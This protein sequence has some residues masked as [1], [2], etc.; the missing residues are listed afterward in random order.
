MLCHMSWFEKMPEVSVVLPVFNGATTI[1]RAVRSMLQ[2]TLEEIELIVVDDGS[3]DETLR[4]LR[5][6]ED[7]RL[8]IMEAEHTGVAAA[9]NLGTA[10]ARA[11]VIARMDA[12]DFSYPHRL[13][14]QLGLLRQGYDAV[15]CQVRIVDSEERRVESMR[16]YER[17][18]NEETLS[19]DQISALRFV[20]FPLV[21]PTIL[22]KRAYFELGF[23]N[24]DFP[25]DYDL[26]LRGAGQGMRF[27]KVPQVLFDW[28]DGPNRLT[29]T[30]PRYSDDA[31]MRCRRQRLLEGPLRHIEVVDVWGAGKTGKPWLRWLREQDIKIRHLYD[32]SPRKVGN[33]IQDARVQG[34]ESL[35]EADGTPLLIAVGSENARDV[36]RPQLASRGYVPGVDAWFVA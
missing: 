21:N 20:E 9:A 5:S 34:V 11:D 3:T 32:V 8:N 12:D 6:F 36:I 23:Q 35:F 10:A 19:N 4:L 31:F 28:Y 17:W 24:D 14:E 22:A 30:D 25:E 7:P 1:E 15:G 29:R 26:L 18:V 2:Q 27:G 13:E 16:R 33:L